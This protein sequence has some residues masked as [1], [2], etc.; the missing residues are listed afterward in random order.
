[1]H[2]VWDH[3]C[4]RKEGPPHGQ[5][6]L[7]WWRELVHH[8]SGGGNWLVA[9]VKPN[10]AYFTSVRASRLTAVVAQLLRNHPHSPFPVLFRSFTSASVFQTLHPSPWGEGETGTSTSSPSSSWPMVSPTSP[11]GGRGFP[12]VVFYQWSVCGCRTAGEDAAVHGGDAVPGLQSGGGKLRLQG[13][14]NLQGAI[15]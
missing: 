9:S 7:L 2:P 15:D 4:E 14:Q 5:E 13:G 10:R 11:G 3:V 6:P 8:P 1:M 12:G